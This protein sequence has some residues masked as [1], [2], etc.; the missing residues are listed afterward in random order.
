MSNSNAYNCYVGRMGETVLGSNRTI[1]AQPYAGVMFKSQNGST[2]S[3]E[4]NEDVKFIMNRAEF[5]IVGGTV[6][7]VNDTLP[8]R[9]LKDNPIRTT[10]ASGTFRVFHPNHGMH[11]TSNNVTIAGVPSGTYN[12]IAHSVINGTHTTISNITLDSYDISLLDSTVATATGDVGGSA[13]TATQNRAYDVANLN[14]QTMAVPGTSLSAKMRPTTGKSLHGSESE[15]SLTAAASAGSVV[16]NDN[17][18]CTSP[19]IVASEINETNEMSGSKSLFVTL[20]LA[21][22]NSKVS[23]VIDTQRMSMIAIQN[24]L[25]NPLSGNT[26]S[27]VADT[28]ATGS[29]SSAQYITRAISLENPSQALDI[30]LTANVRSTSEIEMFYRTTS[31]DESRKI[32]D[33]TWTPF[34]TDGSPDTAV[35]PAEDD[36]T[37]KEHKFS[38]SSINSFTGF[39]LKIVLK[40]TV[41]SYPPVI[42]D[43]RGIALA[44]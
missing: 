2:W 33:L 17:I 40:G 42:K 10:N 21:S 13:V 38:A 30:R 7:L 37:F 32:E 34:N 24:R 6:T 8:T 4:Q 22:T 23:P 31:A 11:G 5:N 44:V 18:Y 19:K 35:S 39:Q 9:T 12:G 26:P 29:S 27:F 16:T 36:D 14:I 25:T 15:F 20:T 1:S 43:M 28:A 3:A 41:S